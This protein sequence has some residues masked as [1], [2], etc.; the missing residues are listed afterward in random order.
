[1]GLTARRLV[2]VCATMLFIPFAGAQQ[3]SAA[4]QYNLTSQTT[5]H[6]TQ[7]ISAN[8]V[9]P[10]NDD[11]LYVD[12]GGL[13][14]LPGNGKGGVTMPSR[15][16]LPNVVQAVSGRFTGNSLDDLVVMRYTDAGDS[17]VEL[18][19]L[20][21]QG[22]GKFA[23]PAS[24]AIPHAHLTSACTLTSG[25][26]NNDGTPDIMVVCPH[27]DGS[28]FA[29][30][31]NGKGTFTFQAMAL[32]P[33]SEIASVAVADFNGDGKA[34]LFVKSSTSYDAK[35]NMDILWG[36]ASGAF[37]L[38]PQT[39][40]L[41]GTPI[42]ADYNGA[43]ADDFLMLT[44]DEIAAYR[45]GAKLTADQVLRPDQGCSF[46]D[47]APEVA[48]SVGSRAE[49][50]VALEDCSEAGDGNPFRIRVY[51]N[52]E[53]TTLRLIPSVSY[54]KGKYVTT[55]NYTLG[56]PYSTVPQGGWSLTFMVDGKITHTLTL[57]AAK[58]H[59][60][61]VLAKGEHR[62]L[63]AY[64]GDATHAAAMYGFHI[65]IRN[66]DS[67]STYPRP[68][69]AFGTILPRTTHIS[70]SPFTSYYHVLPIAYNSR[71]VTSPRL[72]LSQTGCTPKAPGDSCTTTA[73]SGT[74]LTEWETSTPLSASASSITVGT[75]WGVSSQVSSAPVDG[76]AQAKEE[77]DPPSINPNDTA[78]TCNM[79]DPGCQQGATAILDGV[80]QSSPVTYSDTDKMVEWPATLCAH[81]S[82]AGCYT[83]DTVF[84]TLNWSSS[85]IPVGTH[86]LYFKI[87]DPVYGVWNTQPVSLTVTAASNQAGI[88]SP[89]VSSPLGHT[90]GPALLST[91]A[92]AQIVTSGTTGSTTTISSSLNPS[93]YGQAVTFTAGATSGA[94]GLF[95]FYDG[96]TLMGQAP[97]GWS[98]EDVAYDSA[99]GEIYVANPNSGIIF[100]FN[101]STGAYITNIDLPTAATSG[102]KLAANSS[103][104]TI[105]A[106][107]SGE[108]LFIS[109]STNTITATT[110]ISGLVPFAIGADP[111]NN[112]NLAIVTN[113]SDS[114]ANAGIVAVIPES[115]HAAETIS[116]CGGC[117][118]QRVAVDTSTGN[119]YVGAIYLEYGYGSSSNP[120]RI[121]PMSDS[122]G[123]VGS[124][125]YVGSPV[126]DSSLA[127]DPN[128]HVLYVNGTNK[129]TGT[130]QIWSLASGSNTF[131]IANNSTPLF[132]QMVPTSSSGLLYGLASGSPTLYTYAEASNSISNTTT[133]P[134]QVSTSLGGMSLNPSSGQLY[135]SGGS[136][137]NAIW[138]VNTSTYA[139]A[140]IIHEQYTT[141]ALS[142][143]SHTIAADYSGNDAYAPSSASLTQVVNTPTTTTSLSCSPATFTYGSTTG[144]TCTAAVSGNSPTGTVTFYFS[145]GTVW[146]TQTLSGGSASATG[147]NTD[148]APMS[149]GVYAVY[150][151]D[152]NNNSST[153][154]TVTISITKATPSISYSCS[155]ST[156]TVGGAS[157]NCTATVSGVSGGATPTGTVTMT[158]NGNSWVTLS[159]NNGSATQAFNNAVGSYTMS[160]TYNGDGNYNGGANATASLTVQKATPSFSIACSGPN[161]YGS[162]N[163]NCTPTV[164]GGDSPTGTISW[165]FSTSGSC[166]PGSWTT[167][168]GLSQS[169]GNWAG[170]SAGNYTVCAAYTGDSNN[171]STS[172]TTSF[173]INKMTP[174]MATSCSPNPDIYGGTYQCSATVSG[175][176]TG[177]V[178]FGSPL[179]GGAAESL[180]SG[181]AMGPVGTVTSAPGTYT[182]TFT[183]NGDSNHN[184]ASATATLAVTQAPSS[185]SLS[186][187][188]NSLTF[189]SSSGGADCTATVSGASPTGTVTFNLNNGGGTATVALSGNS[190]SW[191]AVCANSGCNPGSYPV[192]ATY[193]GDTNNS[194]SSGNT[195]LT[196]QPAVSSVTLDA[197]TQ[198]QQWQA[199][200]LSHTSGYG[201]ASGTNWVATTSDATGCCG[202]QYGPYATNL[203]AGE[204][205]IA[206]W[207]MEVD[208]NSAD[209]NQI[210][211]VDVYDDATNTV[212]ASET[213]T[214]KQFAA[215]NTFQTF[216][217]PFNAPSPA[218]EYEIRVSYQG[219]ATLTEKY[220]QIS[221]ASGSSAY[222]QAVT[223][224]A[225][226][227]VVNGLVP[228]GTVT[229]YDNGTA[230]GSAPVS[231]SN[232]AIATAT[233]TV[234]NLPVGSNP[235]TA[236]YSGDGNYSAATSTGV[237]QTVSQ[238]T[239]AVSIASSSPTSTYAQSVTFTCSATANGN[240]V[241]DGTPITFSVDG[242]VESTTS[243]VSGSATWSTSS[244]S[245]GNHTLACTTGGTNYTVGSASLTQLVAGATPSVTITSGQ[246]PSSYGTPVTFTATV[247]G[248]G[249]TPTGTVQF[250]I[251]GTTCDAAVALNGSGVATFQ[252]DT[253]SLNACSWMYG[254]ANSITAIYSGDVNYQMTSASYTETVNPVAL[255]LVLQSEDNPGAVTQP[256][257]FN[258]SSDINL[259]PADQLPSGGVAETPT[260]TVT[261]Y[262]GG[263]E[264]GT[265]PAAY[266]TL[267]TTSSLGL[268]THSITAVYS[269]DKNYQPATSSTL[270]ETIVKETAISSINVA[271]SM[272]VSYGTSL[273]FTDVL[274][275]YGSQPTGGVT[276]MDGTTA[277]GTGTIS[278]VPVT[279]LIIQSN[280]FA[281]AARHGGDMPCSG[282]CSSPYPMGEWLVEAPLTTG[283]RGNLVQEVNYPTT[284][285]AVVTGPGGAPI[286]TGG[287]Q[288][289]F[290]DTSAG[291]QLGSLYS[292]VVENLATTALAGKSATFSVW[293]E[294]ASSTPATVSLYMADMTSGTTLG[295]TSCTLGS[296][297][298]RCSV[299]GTFPS[300]ST[301]AIVSMRSW[302]ATAETVNAWG[303]QL[304]QASAP[305]PYV[306][307]TTAAATGSGGIATFTTVS[308]LSVGSHTI[309]AV[310]GGD[311]DF[312]SNT[313]PAASVTVNKALVAISA[314][315]DH[316]PS[317]H[318]QTVT[319]TVTVAP[320]SGV[321]T[322]P[323]G[324]VTILNGTTSIGTGTLNSS[325]VA[326]ITTSGLPT[327]SDQ[328]TVRYDG[329]TNYY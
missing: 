45:G 300:T 105:Y 269:G 316:N 82:G 217:L 197:G 17:D 212:V 245:V 311:A 309:T 185:T 133:L 293:L 181:T 170:Y 209:N 95:S 205:N 243:T 102:I 317:T 137:A 188:P 116:L 72:P 34:D 117:L 253:Q 131:T 246:N 121:Y 144:S 138:N 233:V 284:S 261:F 28:V 200:S 148:N 227:P 165:G 196:I 266:P 263:T 70:F 32:Q 52:T 296:T 58:G 187:S 143:G 157:S 81:G 87:N 257:T 329:D 328:L 258:A 262:D 3:W 177:T 314:L 153:S 218:Y 326:T 106:A 23:A 175:G 31:N 216:S 20:V 122:F 123:S 55:M 174:T 265:A 320:P 287:A 211:Y 120:Y 163:V 75:S 250:E 134:A 214:R 33:G 193:S 124:G 241:L 125:T 19:L 260:G 180:V 294:S 198:I 41:Q 11:L 213:I 159:L 299:T 69:S 68:P 286:S 164:S 16:V 98:T 256:V 291:G 50:I 6:V 156:V 79:T 160:A 215:A 303:A 1:M 111:V 167:G 25:D 207:S 169:V 319:F 186:C 295:T 161:T 221:G 108:V 71:L 83:A 222:G 118:A 47:A 110:S 59:F 275:T 74:G 113:N 238:A 12:Q 129:G 142:A 27:N 4:Q 292:G 49:N 10:E 135:I 162:V 290:P 9:A 36:S 130:P 191:T 274:S 140:N 65:W 327:G 89:A 176:A 322:L 229:F 112:L 78:D 297:W 228:T 247:A 283:S 201:S 18:F 202:F 279:N 99:N 2:A 195:T 13:E 239:P 168:Q 252:S 242:T 302:G 39:L 103:S 276:F 60:D 234:T 231:A 237:T 15:N 235:I 189:G 230:I 93:N 46:I 48:L 132:E 313:S 315:S 306:Q 310:Y 190:A 255:P 184:S 268:G 324:T 251:N 270:T 88:H 312:T 289:A 259:L 152:T 192:S 119:W 67:T 225:S 104:N 146:T 128:S 101:A 127:V 155:P 199:A 249:A 77:E 51:T 145:G 277:L 40:A 264:I 100:V 136:A 94:G 126:Q 254:G 90:F 61:V 232:S 298:T 204:M 64:F 150:N 86:T 53:T 206:T 178:T 43:L 240:P 323:T 226:V 63:A 149:T 282:R 210:A 224:S 29:G 35:P 57:H 30:I 85:S 203:L 166:T 7:I 236:K 73:A 220:A 182:A 114:G 96:A 139:E 91:Q 38:A 76:Q 42:S 172:A 318:N 280:G 66:L 278:S 84:T 219:G 141:S 24:I 14:L 281:L 115:T 109:G 304:E 301:A 171:N 97:I 321:A 22:N 271:P 158:Y 173:V 147:W 208:N 179:G 248:S 154:N 80:A 273:T 56:S 26:L 194:A 325:G 21:N 244:L 44:P 183:Y 272:S 288:I 37:S 307:T 308:P 107:I 285:A 305:G 54:E 62:V 223:L 151:G 92:T 5:T 267:F 8:V